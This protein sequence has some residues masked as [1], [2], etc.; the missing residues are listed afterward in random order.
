M[1]GW[2]IFP[3]TVT[4]VAFAMALA[5]SLGVER[6]V[7]AVARFEP[8]SRARLLGLVCLLPTLAALVITAMGFVPTLLFDLGVVHDWCLARQPADHLACP[9]HPQTV[10][11]GTAVLALALAA[12]GVVAIA[13]AHA[14]AQLV[15][16]R[17]V[18]ARLDSLAEPGATGV[19][20]VV[21]SDCAV[22]LSTTWPRERIYVS[23]GVLAAM[24]AAELDGLLAHERAHIERRDTMRLLLVRLASLALLPR[25]RRRLLAALE[26]AIEQACDQVAARR[27]GPLSVASALVKFSRAAAGPAPAPLVSAYGGADIALRVQALVAARDGIEAAP[28]LRANPW[29]LAALVP[30]CWLLHEL[31]EF[32]LRPLVG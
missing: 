9:M 8:A 3:A 1:T 10:G 20:R 24:D 27:V 19:V 13:F 12:A 15:R 6:I 30:A 16:A 4:A 25:A 7:R 31:G 21:R 2:L 14:M 22:A 18:L 5:L 26:L 28:V 32:L 17:R 11:I 29:L 23:R